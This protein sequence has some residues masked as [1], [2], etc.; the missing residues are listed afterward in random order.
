MF[1]CHA[2]R[3]K[4]ETQ[5][6]SG[7]TGVIPILIKST[8]GIIGASITSAWA[9]ISPVALEGHIPGA[10]NS[11]VP[12]QLAVL[13]CF[14]LQWESTFAFQSAMQCDLLPDSRVVLADGVGDGCLG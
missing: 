3:Q 6:H 1:C 11:T 8:L 14:A 13:V 12:P 9:A 10:S 7:V 5:S 2:A 4:K